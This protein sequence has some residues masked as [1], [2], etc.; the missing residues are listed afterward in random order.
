MF[1]YSVNTG[2]VSIIHSI[3]RIIGVLK[4]WKAEFSGLR[5]FNSL[6]PKPS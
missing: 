2:L 6:N 3:H 1:K 4:G 5:S